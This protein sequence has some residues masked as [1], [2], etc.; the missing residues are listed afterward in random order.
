[1]ESKPPHAVAAVGWTARRSRGA[2]GV[3]RACINPLRDERILREAMKVNFLGVNKSISI[4]LRFRIGL[5]SG[6]SLRR[7]RYE[8]IYSFQLRGNVKLTI[9]SDSYTPAIGTHSIVLLYL[10]TS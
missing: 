7:N 5:L 8:A 1:V 4:Y 3:L 6:D 10:Y 2:A 9:Q